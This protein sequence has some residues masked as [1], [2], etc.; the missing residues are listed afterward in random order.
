MENN[1]SFLD[2]FSDAYCSVLRF[3]EK[4]DAIPIKGDGR[5]T[6]RWNEENHGLKI[7]KI[8]AKND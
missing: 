2:G 8:E 5:L 4:D 1:M 6:Q 7:T 3:G